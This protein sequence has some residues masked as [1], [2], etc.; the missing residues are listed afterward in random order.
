MWH[1]EEDSLYWIDIAACV[2]HRLHITSKTHRSWSLPSAP[3]CIA[4]NATGGLVVALR[5]GLVHLNTDTG[6]ITPLLPAPYDTNL[7][8]FNDGRCDA[9]GRLWCGSIYEPRGQALATLYRIE[10]NTL[11]DMHHAVTTSNGVAFTVDQHQMFHS[12]TPSHRI[13]IYDFDL[14]TG[15]TS[16]GHLFHQF[17]ADKSAPDYGGRPDGAAVDSENAYWCAMYEGGRLLRLAPTGKILQEI[18]LP[19]RCP[20][21]LAFG[22]HDLRTLYI[23]SV[24]DKRPAEELE[25]YPHSG[26][27]LSFRVDVPGQL[28]YAYIQ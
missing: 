18:P 5:T 16:N 10:H 9:M 27:L 20:T 17:N 24:R 15:Q 13:N 4:R 12:D 11:K 21:M 28:E 8:R 3:G 7:I 25:Q 22:G 6:T 19:V 23:T 1:A 26:C 14:A 2:V